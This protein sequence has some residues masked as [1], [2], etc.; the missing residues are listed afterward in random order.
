[1]FTVNV[2]SSKVLGR[3]DNVDREGSA[4]DGSKGNLFVVFGDG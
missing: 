3:V 4:E 2:I 1:M